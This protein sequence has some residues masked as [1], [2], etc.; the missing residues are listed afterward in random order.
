MF[1]C[2][3]SQYPERV[4]ADSLMKCKIK[5]AVGVTL[6]MRRGFRNSDFLPYQSAR[7]FLNRN[8]G[9]KTTP[10]QTNAMSSPHETSRP[11][12][13]HPKFDVRLKCHICRNLIRHLR[14]TL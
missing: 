6:R 12:Q 10:L 3:I 1:F 7:E 4:G 5:K 8:H 13:M 2:Y 9:I 14:L 11:P